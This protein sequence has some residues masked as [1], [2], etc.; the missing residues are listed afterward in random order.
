MKHKTDIR[1]HAFVLY[2][3]GYSFDRITAILEEEGSKVARR[4]LINWEKRFD[5]KQR[6]QKIQSE[7]QTKIDKKQVS[8]LTRLSS[9]LTELQSDLMVE[10]KNVRLKTKEGGVAA[11]RQIHEMRQKLLSDKRFE[12]HLDELIQI[13]FEILAN[14][15]IIGPKLKDRQQIIAEKLE[16][17][18]K[19]KY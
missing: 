10:L 9:D 2:A 11:L 3:Q 13:I 18:L 6:R 19:D 7:V 17:T 8:E 1:E 12:E 16:K 15:D 4:T 14:D 5:W